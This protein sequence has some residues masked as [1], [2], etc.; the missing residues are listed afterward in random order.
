MFVP[1]TTSIL[2]SPKSND[3][4]KNYKMAVATPKPKPLKKSIKENGYHTGF[5]SSN[6]SY[7]STPFD[8]ETIEVK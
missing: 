2:N 1:K 5:V 6:N 8:C 3:F 7:V 4:L